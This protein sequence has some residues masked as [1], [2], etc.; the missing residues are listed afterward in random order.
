MTLKAIKGNRA[1]KGE[2][3]RDNLAKRRREL[4][5]TW[6]GKPLMY[7]WCSAEAL[8]TAGELWEPSKPFGSMA[9]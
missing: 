9:R 6:Q 2:G 1:A 7:G 3:L 8:S 4:H 5:L